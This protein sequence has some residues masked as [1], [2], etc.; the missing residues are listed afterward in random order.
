MRARSARN[1]L[2][3][4]ILAAAI[5]IGLGSGLGARPASAQGAVG[6][7]YMSSYRVSDYFAAPGWYGTSYGFA[8]YGFPQTYS[9]FSAYPGPSYGNNYPPYGLLPGRYGVGLWRPGYVTPGYA[10]GASYY[11]SSGFSYRTFPVMYGS[12]GRAMDPAPPFGYYA[13]SFGPGP[14]PRPAALRTY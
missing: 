12:A 8:S 6:T 7:P 10:Y 14:D 5:G 3:G 1:R 4:T 9:V 13:P 11:P 2:A